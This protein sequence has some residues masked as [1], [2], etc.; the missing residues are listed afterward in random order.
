MI[1]L[2]SWRHNLDSLKH[3]LDI[4]QLITIYGEELDYGR[5]MEDAARHETKKR[6]VRT[7]SIIYQECTFLEKIKPFPYKKES[8]YLSYD[9]KKGRFGGRLRRYADFIDYQFLSYDK[10]NQMIH[11][12]V[13]W[14]KS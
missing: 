5:L 12:V 1:C 2:H 8:S 10:T 11:E 9:A 6:L 13:K 7:L 3:Y 4:I 14:V